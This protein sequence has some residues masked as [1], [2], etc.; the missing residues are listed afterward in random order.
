STI[1]SY[2]WMSSDS[3]L[4]A[5]H[6]RQS[7]RETLW[8]G[9]TARIGT[10]G[11]RRAIRTAVVPLEVKATTAAAPM[12][13]A[14]PAAAAATAWGAVSSSPGSEAFMM[15]RYILCRSVLA[16]MR[17]IIAT[18][19]RGYWPLADSADNITASAPS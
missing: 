13:S 19:S 4:W 6:N 1:S 14:R 17:L 16:M 18:A 3:T 10:F 12:D 5:P 2:E 15:E 8:S 7:S 9:V 11:R